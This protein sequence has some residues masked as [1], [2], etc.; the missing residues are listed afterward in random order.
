MVTQTEF[1]SGWVCAFTVQLMEY[2]TQ[3]VHPNEGHQFRTS[4]PRA[5]LWIILQTSFIDCIASYLFH[6]AFS[7]SEM[8]Y[9]VGFSRDT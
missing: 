5:T 1:H 8:C 6:M 7:L 3:L 9:I 4:T 2:L